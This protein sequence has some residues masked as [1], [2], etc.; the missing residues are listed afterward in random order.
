MDETQIT[1][2][3]V[4]PSWKLQGNAQG[5]DLYY[6][7]KSAAS[8]IHKT[9]AGDKESATLSGLL[10]GTDYEWYIT[11][12]CRTGNSMASPNSYF[13][14][15]PGAVAV[16]SPSNIQKPVPASALQLAVFPNPTSSSTTISFSLPTPQKVSVKI[17]DMSGRLINTITESAF[18]AGQHQLHWNAAYVHGGIYVL[19]IDAGNYKETKR[20]VVVK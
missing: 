15:Q 18:A 4:K 10:P 12:A 7:S 3:S 5:F 8:W 20:L 9:V 17:F 6:R 19:R 1:T 11:A 2:S 16:N 14:T 13:T